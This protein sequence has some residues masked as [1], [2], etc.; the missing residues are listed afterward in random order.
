MSKLGSNKQHVP[1]YISALLPLYRADHH[2]QQ[3][4]RIHFPEENKLSFRYI[5]TQGEYLK[6][7]S[8]LTTLK[9]QVPVFKKY[10][11]NKVKYSEC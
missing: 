4:A 1:F 10:I 7:K 5:P 6:Q 2:W 11:E 3:M 8:N 9:Q